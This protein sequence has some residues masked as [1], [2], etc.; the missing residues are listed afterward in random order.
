[1]GNSE[2]Q[3]IGSS[4][5]N[6]IIALLLSGQTSK[7]IERLEADPSGTFLND[8]INFRKDNLLHYACAKNNTTL[9]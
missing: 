7:V 4:I 2:E 5:D 8:S 1:M 9:A 6:N 3:Q